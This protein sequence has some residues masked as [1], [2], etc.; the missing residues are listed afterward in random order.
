MGTLEIFGNK[1]KVEAILGHLA[2]QTLLPTLLNPGSAYSRYKVQTNYLT[3]TYTIDNV[4]V[5][6]HQLHSKENK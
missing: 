1:R 3:Y 6:D 4:V 5:R 2:H